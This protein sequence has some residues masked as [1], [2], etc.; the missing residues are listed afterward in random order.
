MGFGDYKLKINPLRNNRQETPK[1]FNTRNDNP[2]P[3]FNTPDS[4]RNENTNRGNMFA[5]KLNRTLALQTQSGGSGNIREDVVNDYV[6][7]SLN[8]GA[9]NLASGLQ[10]SDLSEAEKFAIIQR[11][12]RNEDSYQAANA[13]LIFQQNDSS[14]V[15]LENRQNQIDSIA[16]WMNKAYQEGAITDADLTNLLENFGEGDAEMLIANL[17]NSY[18]GTQRD[19]IVEALGE[20]AETLGYERAA[21]LAF[22]SSTELILEHIPNTPEASMEAFNL[23]NSYLQERDEFSELESIHGGTSPS[24]TIRLNIAAENIGNLLVMR[25]K[26]IFGSLLNSTPDAEGQADLVELFQRTIYSPFV[27]SEARNQIQSSID[28][29]IGNSIRLAGNDSSTVGRD[30][31]TMLGVLQFASQRAIE[32]A[33]TPEEASAI[34][35]YA[36]LGI[37]TIAST[38]TGLL[39]ASTGPVTAALGSTVVATVVSNVFGADSPDPDALEDAFL[40]NLQASGGSTNVGE[41][42]IDKI[43]D[44]QDALLGELNTR[45][46]AST[47]AQERQELQEAI[48][49][50]EQLLGSTND[51]FQNT[52]LSGN[53]GSLREELNSRD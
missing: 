47:N 3:S 36:A 2:N 40:E 1:P 41:A 37:S 21:A 22:T 34:Q 25:D 17:S 16:L 20:H 28:Q 26:D 18:S 32:E 11:I 50:T 4:I 49:Q 27:G 52:I 15:A 30:V 39:L 8:F 35:G 29:F 10:D 51:G 6:E 48:N 12:V 38:V 33:R 53:G 23:V 46:E 31:G 24:D 14:D 9:Q 13:L 42:M 5:F 45:L 19:G 44:L 43:N 7:Y